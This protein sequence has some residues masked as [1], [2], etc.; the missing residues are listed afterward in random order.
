MSTTHNT[1]PLAPAPRPT[2]AATLALLWALFAPATVPAQERVPALDFDFGHAAAGND[3]PT[4]IWSDGAT[5][6]VADDVDARLYAYDMA[7]RRRNHTQAFDLQAAGNRAPTGLWS[8]GT[9]MWV[10][11]FD[12]GKLYAYHLQSGA[13][14]APNDFNTLT[15]TGN[16]APTG[17]WSDGTTMWVADAD[18]AKLY[19][20]HLATRAWDPARDVH[21][22]DQADNDSPRGLWSDGTTMWV[23]DR[24]DRRLYAYRLAS[25]AR[26][27]DRD[28]ATVARGNVAPFG[29]WSDRETLWVSDL[30]A[31]K[32]YAYDRAGSHNSQH[33]FNTLYREGA[34]KPL[35]LWSDG[36]TIWILHTE[37]FTNF[38]S[39][40]YAYD[41]AT[42][43]RR[44]AKDFDSLT[45][46]GNEIPRGIWSDG[47]TMWIANA[48]SYAETKVYAY[49]L[50]TTTRDADKDFDT[51]E[52]T[53][54]YNPWGIWSDGTTMWIAH[55][56]RGR[57]ANKLYAYNL[58]TKV[59]DPDKDF[60]T[61]HAAGNHSPRGIWSDGTTMWVAD[62]SN[63]KLYAYSM[64]TREHDHP[65]DF[66]TLDVQGNTRP[67]GLWSD[68]STMW[69]TNHEF[70]PGST[71]YAYN[72]A[73][74]YRDPVK[75]FS[76]STLYLEWNGSPTGLWSDGT[77]MWVAD[78]YDLKLYA[79][80]L[81]SKDRDP[82]EDFDTLRAAGNGSPEAIWSDGTTMWVAD[83][84]DDKLYAYSLATKNRHPAKDFDGLAAAGNRSPE[85][86]W[87][88]GATMW[89]TD[90]PSFSPH[91]NA[92]LYAYNLATE[93]RHPDEDFNMLDA[94]GNDSP[95][96]IWSDGIA[97][98]I[99]DDADGKLYAY[100]LVRKSRNAAQDVDT[101]GAAG[102]DRPAG[103]WSD[104]TTIWVADYNDNR[105]YAYRLPNA[106]ADPQVEV[107]PTFLTVDEAGGTATYTLRL[108]TAP[109][110]PVTVVPHS[111]DSTAARASGPVT[112]TPRD[113][114]TPLTVAV[115]GVDDDIDNPDDRRTTVIRHR[116]AG[117]GYDA[118]TIADVTVT[119]TDDDDDGG[120][121]DEDED[122]DDSIAELVLRWPVA[123]RDIQPGG[124]LT[125]DYAHYGYVDDEKYHTGI[126]IAAAAGTSVVAAAAGEIVF[127]Q[128]YEDGCDSGCE[129]HDLG[130]TI[131]IEHGEK[132]YTQYSHLQKGSVFFTGDPDI[133]KECPVERDKM[134]RR[135]CREGVGVEAGHPLGKV[136]TTGCNR[137]GCGPHLHFELK[138]HNTLGSTGHDSPE[139]GYSA[140][141]P[142]QSGWYDPVV[143]LHRATAQ[144]TGTRVRVRPEGDKVRLRGGPGGVR[145]ETS[146]TS[147]PVHREY[148]V[149]RTLAEGE[150]YE[151]VNL[152]A[153]TVEP[154]CPGG[155]YQVKHPQAET[156][157]RGFEALSWGGENARIPDG[158][159]CLSDG[160]HKL[161][162][163]L[164]TAPQPFTDHPL[165]P[166]VTPVKAVHFTQLRTRIDE[167]RA[168]EGL[169][170]FAWTDPVLSAGVTRVRLYHLMELRFALEAAY[171]VAGRPAP[172][173]TDAAPP[174]EGRTPIRAAHLMELRAAVIA[175]Q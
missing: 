35:D 126:D 130:T 43:S 174:V 37:G 114:A 117:G 151:A 121:D 6:W 77:T 45:A 113:W 150:E 95:R 175:L 74:K 91:A 75:E 133:E 106:A 58:A 14:D 107:S 8:D 156:S 61:L 134:G 89:V 39:K 4:G 101:L 16:R 24:E 166:G 34:H 80:N 55:D 7:T 158:W 169:P 125:N 120:D 172:P 12:D 110:G 57:D 44:P 155:W 170:R 42:K 21:A 154:S 5:M 78:S 127:I 86:I 171:A 40:L 138:D 102:N 33:D 119:V 157:G 73:T 103:L 49:N 143:N 137:D 52:A 85:G 109:R 79:Y 136:G 9:T 167:L 162:E 160:D 97:M 93:S 28:L 62:S 135:V 11:D 72:L 123:V 128:E 22:L 67:S 94:A 104:R 41:L 3:A 69:V 139:W 53:G 51:L 116:A 66:N 111:D 129:D 124:L 20:Y 161:L 112:F 141:H 87:S 96:A 81:T 47:T 152:A 30:S 140:K 59:R 68:G 146:D 71:V 17:I 144:P 164:G 32:L 65:K 108:T 99:A 27:V 83:S 122:E 64:A 132:V 149:I 10:A 46:A 63:D 145:D 153:A 118:V 131:I 159:I 56:D 115:T 25:G 76:A 84:W 48:Q 148:P 100:S 163:V 19:A 36:T 92:K 31:A 60:D 98:W 1:R 142:R 147:R 70:G 165:V 168:A 26:D 2:T 13:R 82:P 50:A 38:T 90:D 23:A 29:V 15:V 173:W 54:N 18:D 88:D 105:L